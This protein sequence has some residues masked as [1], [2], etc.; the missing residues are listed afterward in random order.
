MKTYCNC[1]A[2]KGLLEHVNGL[3]EGYTIVNGI[4][5]DAGKFE[6]ESVA[7]LYYYDCT[8]YHA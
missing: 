3:S 2:C 1:I 8:L 6:G 5:K 7:S 4:I